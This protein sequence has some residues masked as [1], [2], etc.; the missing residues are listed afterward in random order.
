M[1]HFF[2]ILEIR[3]SHSIA[4]CLSVDKVSATGVDRMPRS[5]LATLVI[6]LLLAPAACHAQNI[7]SILQ[8]AMQAAERGEHD[9]AIAKLS[10]AIKS[11]P[12]TPLPWYL[13]GR[14]NF[15]TGKIAESVADFDKSIQLEPQASI[16]AA[17]NPPQRELLNQRLFYAHLYIGL[18]HEAAGESD[19]AKEHI[20]EAEKHKVGHY[21]WDVAHVH[22]DRLRS[23][24]KNNP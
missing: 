9:R 11:S 24:Q 20:L 17:P 18:W 6:A 12:M 21:M 10:E 5:L 14:E 15:R 4:H 22:A 2:P 13:R 23:Q 19:K 7:D 8:E 3:F 16:T 1:T